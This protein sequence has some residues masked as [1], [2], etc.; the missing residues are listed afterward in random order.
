MN[1]NKIMAKKISVIGLGPVGYATAVGFAKLG[2]NVVGVDLI[3]NKVDK[4]N[5]LNNK[6]LRATL[7]LEGAI[8][9]SDISFICVETPIKRDG[10]INLT[11]LEKVSNDIGKI[12]QNKKYHII[13]FRSTMFPNSLGLLKNILE[14]SSGKKCGKDFDLVIN[15]EFLREAHAIK[16]FFNPSLIVVGSNNK[17][18]GKQVMEYYKNIKAKK[19]I[20]NE[21]IAQM[22]KY[23]NNSFHAL[24]VVFSNEIAAICKKINVDSKKLMELFCEDT[25]LNI[26]PYYLK[27]G[28]AYSGRCI[29]K[30]LA[31]LQK[32]AKRLRIKCP[33]INSISESN[34]IQILRDKK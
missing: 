28:K 32:R 20:V 27:P 16:D 8:L 24:K 7:D 26:S 5:K 23:T 9:W 6:K 3:Y 25:D 15:P 31:I 19:F 30:D 2:H 4:I 21:N 12:L 10:D 22:I 13:V 18:V 1:E 17:K 33:I 11:A 34:K 14:K 29:P